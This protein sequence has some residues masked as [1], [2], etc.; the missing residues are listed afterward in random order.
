MNT[1]L[2]THIVYKI[3]KKVISRTT[4]RVLFIGF[5]TMDTVEPASHSAVSL[6]SRQQT[7]VGDVWMCQLTIYT[8]NCVICVSEPQ[9]T[10]LTQSYNW[11][12]RSEHG[13]TSIHCQY[14]QH[15]M[16]CCYWCEDT[17]MRRTTI[18]AAYDNCNLEWCVEPKELKGC[19]N[20]SN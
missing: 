7:T 4:N 11:Q 17:F 5:S 15:W 19:K 9:N 14:F 12:C 8:N 1:F 18:S 20:R 3:C 2:N 13:S 10:H 16:Y 6:F